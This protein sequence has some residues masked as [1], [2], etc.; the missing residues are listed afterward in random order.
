MPKREPIEWCD[1]WV[2]HADAEAALPR[3]LLVGDSIARSYHHG[4]E[5]RLAGR[6]HVARLATS[7]SV[8]DPAFCRELALL[9]DDYAFALVHL[10]NG[11]HGMD[12]N[13][14]EY[15]RA[16]GSVFDFLIQHGRRAR[17]IWA[18]ST[19]LRRHDRPAEFAPQ[20]A[21]VAERNRIAHALAAARGIP[22]NDLFALVHDH[23]EFHAEDGVHF[24]TAG[25]AALAERVAE[26]V[27]GL[28]VPESSASAKP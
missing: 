27:L 22:V 26:F 7:R 23:P 6:C 9:L 28:G 2:A 14:V 15:G 10:N 21:R 20:T 5:Q 11:L 17:V 16:L 19:P 12:Y 3:L 4:V 25:Q 8:C 18:H 1:T 24:N 13:E